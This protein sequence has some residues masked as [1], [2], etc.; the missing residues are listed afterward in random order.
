MR[1]NRTQDISGIPNWISN[2]QGFNGIEKK[3]E[4]FL[5]E[6]SK[7]NCI[8]S[9]KVDE[10]AL[11]KECEKIEKCAS[12]NKEYFFNNTWDKEHIGH[13]KE[14]A[15]VCG[16]ENDKLVGINPNE[17][18]RIA[19]QNNNKFIKTA[20]TS[21]KNENLNSL[22]E[23]L[24]DPFKLQ[25]RSSMDHMEKADWEIITR[26]SK[27]SDS[28]FKSMNGEVVPLRGGENYDEANQQK[29]ANNQNSIV[30]P[31]AL[32]RLYESQE[33]T[34]KE[35]LSRQAKEREDKRKLNH[36]KWE[37]DKIAQMQEDGF[38]SQGV[39]FPTEVS[40]FNTGVKDSF[41]GAYSNEDLQNR[42]EKTLGETLASRNQDRK[43][44]I[45]RDVQENK[46]W[47]SLKEQSSRMVS[48]SFANS[49]K[50]NLK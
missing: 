34:T 28:P 16:L 50:R 40:Y 36:E 39:V 17:I 21:V 35:R 10:D 20:S 45:Q 26:A 48:D 31:D 42:P 9:S 1:V 11:L 25:E 18:E 5:S 41:M 33:E 32:D 6:K 46:E 14:Y 15:S 4:T 19:N 44:A 38:K 2:D 27:L 13:L 49:L 24:G 3:Y 43:Q 23:A 12:S 37:N 7:L 22:S 47:D 29:L 8:S 30:D